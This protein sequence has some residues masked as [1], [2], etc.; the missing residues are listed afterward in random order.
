M[1]LT[2]HSEEY[3]QLSRRID[4]TSK[5]QEQIFRLHVEYIRVIQQCLPETAKVI[6]RRSNKPW[7][8]EEKDRVNAACRAGVSIKE[9]AVR[10]E[11]SEDS[12]R[13]CLSTLEELGKR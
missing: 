4:R 13:K 8:E 12:I 9:I 6:T 10:Q 3:R 7:T 5:A 11:R 1:A 2:V